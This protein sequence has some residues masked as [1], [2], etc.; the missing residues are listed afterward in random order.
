MRKN[1]FN[2]QSG[3]VKGGNKYEQSSGHLTAH[4]EPAVKIWHWL[5]FPKRLRLRRLAEGGRTDL[6][7]DLTARYYKLRGFPVTIFFHICR[8][9][10]LYQ[11][12]DIDRGRSSH[13][14][15]V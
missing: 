2:I 6:L 8:K 13:K 11:F 4:H 9:S 10:I 3:T 7:A 15:R 12:R 14:G 1:K 5:F